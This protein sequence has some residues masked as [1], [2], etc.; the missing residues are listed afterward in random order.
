MHVELIGIALKKVLFGHDVFS[1][2]HWL[3]GVV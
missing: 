2:F 1:G 3:F